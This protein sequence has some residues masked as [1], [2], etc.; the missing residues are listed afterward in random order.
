MSPSRR[1]RVI[2]L[3]TRARRT[4]KGE[5]VPVYVFVVGYFAV[6]MIYARSKYLIFFEYAEK[7][8]AA[9]FE[10]VVL[11]FMVVFKWPY[12]FILIDCHFLYNIVKDWMRR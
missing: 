5:L 12:F 4:L 1:A 6:G 11:V 9:R 8:K 3:E 7:R 2:V 10:M